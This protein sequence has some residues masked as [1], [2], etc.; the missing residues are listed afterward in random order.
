MDD[1]AA[2]KRDLGDL[3]AAFAAID[4]AVAREIEGAPRVPDVAWHAIADGGAP[5]DLPALVR[6]RGCVVGPFAKGPTPD[7]VSGR[8]MRGEPLK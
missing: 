5:R 6:R 3:R 2:L 4:D 7:N 1:I 8:S